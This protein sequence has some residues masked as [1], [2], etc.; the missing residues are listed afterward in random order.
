MYDPLVIDTFMRSWQQLAA[1]TASAAEDP[2]PT[3]TSRSNAPVQIATHPAE[4]AVRAAMASPLD[5]L[6][7]SAVQKT[8]ATLAILFATD[9]DADRLLSVASR[10]TDGPARELISMPLGSGVSGWVAVNGTPILNAEAALDLRRSQ[11]GVELVRI[12]CVPVRVRG[13]NVG[14]LSLYS[15]DRRGFNEEDKT[16][17]QQL[18]AGLDS[19]EPSRAFDTLL[20]ARRAALNSPPTIH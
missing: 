16:L 13:H 4:G 1:E 10:T 17:I 14:V 8:G 3:R 2:K 19:E 5:Q 15:G 9:L 6:L 7:E 11:D 12:V 20:N 18:V